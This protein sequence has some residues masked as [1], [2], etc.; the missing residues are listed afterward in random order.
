MKK[1][2]SL[3]AAGKDDAR[4]R[5]KVRHEINKFLKRSRQKE[6]PEG[7][8]RWNFEC[9]LGNSATEAEVLPWKDLGA[10]ID[11]QA[12]AG[13]TSVYVEVLPVAAER[14]RA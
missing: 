14:S 13:A 7:M 6:L 9:R 2:F 10:A 3:T 11:R 12:E 5:D 4:V 8:T 1:M